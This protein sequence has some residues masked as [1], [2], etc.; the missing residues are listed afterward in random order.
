MENN[1]GKPVKLHVRYLPMTQSQ[2]KELLSAAYEKRESAVYP[3]LPYTFCLFAAVGNE[4]LSHQQWSRS[5]Q[6]RFHHRFE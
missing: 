3:W 1:T 2:N 5:E 6:T 4:I